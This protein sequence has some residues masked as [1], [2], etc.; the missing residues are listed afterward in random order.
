LITTNIIGGLGNQM[1]QYAAGRA[2]SLRLRQQL[3]LDTSDYHDYGLHQG[4][5]LHRIFS[6]IKK[7]AP[8]ER[9]P[10]PA[11][12]LVSLFR[13][14]AR[15]R[16]LN[17]LFSR[18]MLVEPHFSYWSGVTGASNDGYMIGYW[19]SERYFNEFS[20]QI[21]RDFAF[22]SISDD[23]NL[24]LAQR[25]GHT[26]AVSLHVRRG[27]YASDPKNTSIYNICAPEYY[28]AA[29]RHVAERVKDPE[30]FIFSDDIEW[31][32]KNLV[33]PFTH[34]YVSHNSGAASYNDLRLMSMCKHNIIANSSFSW[35]GA[36]LNVN[37]DRIV[38]A[39]AKWF[40]NG[41]DTRDLLPGDWV[42]L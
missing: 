42:K 19:Q 35:W 33:I 39:P 6:Q 11:S 28:E 10:F 20:A 24:N 34:T 7:I 5:E 14:I 15:H 18:T 1:F 30:F 27:D 22:P 25:I 23:V 32:K 36:W 3:R 16:L 13:R 31:A 41:T 2:L 38:V 4:F 12:R 40:V 8:I 21:R 9:I 29:I 37:P 26:N 17:R